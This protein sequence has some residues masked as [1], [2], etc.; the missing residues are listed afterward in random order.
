MKSSLV[1]SKPLYLFRYAIKEI[2]RIQGEKVVDHASQRILI[3]KISF[4]LVSDMS[5]V[6]SRVQSYVI[7]KVRI[8]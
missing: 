7:S 3:L 1:L 8:Y 2:Q 4:I 5:S 6:E